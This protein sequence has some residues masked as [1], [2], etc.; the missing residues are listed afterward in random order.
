MILRGPG[1]S[2]REDLYPAEDRAVYAE[3]GRVGEQLLPFYRYMVLF[4][5]LYTVHGG[6]VNWVA[7]GLGVFA[8]TNELWSFEKYFQRPAGDDDDRTYVFQDL[9]QFGD[10]FADFTEVD[11]PT[12]GR[13]LVGGPNKWASR[14]TPTFMLE[15]ECH[16]NFGF[17]MFH[18]AQMPR[19]AFERIAVAPL[20]DGLWSVTVAIENDRLIPT[21]SGIAQARR[22]GAPDVLTCTPSTGAVVA[23]GR[24]ARFDDRQFEPVLHEPGRL[25]VDSGIRGHDQEDFRF[26]IAAPEGT[27]VTLRYVAEK[28]QD[29]ETTVTLE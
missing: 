13:V 5:D 29:L 10:V 4:K 27:K 25:V 2:Y 24:L 9:L 17:T 11:H 3:I 7:E 14:S 16:R 15:E 28:A 23:S 20:G 26:V 19:L 6:F 8:F 22:I 12:H 21:R 18:A 1:A